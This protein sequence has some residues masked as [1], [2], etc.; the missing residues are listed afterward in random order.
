MPRRARVISPNGIYHVII[1][2][3]NK[4]NIF[5]DDKDRYH[6]IELLKNSV[7]DFSC[8]IYGFCLMGNH[9]H[10]LMKSEEVHVGRVMRT[11]GSKYV[12]WFN[13]KYFRTGCLFQDRFKSVP[14]RNT[15]QFTGTLRY[16]HQNPLL[17]GIVRNGCRYT[18]SSYLEYYRD[19]TCDK[20]IKGWD[21]IARDFTYSVLPREEF[22]RFHE[23]VQTDSENEVAFEIKS[24]L[25]RISDERASDLMAQISGCSNASDFQ[26]MDGELRECFL[27]DLLD[28]RLPI[29]QIVRIT[30]VSKGL[31]QKLR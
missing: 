24:R 29:V 4:Q 10:L 31:I 8:E 28:E 1:R 16:I 30:G 14:V 23:V 18:F 20:R 19:L 11:I 3:I 6:F 22:L 7:D 9:V 26:A 12:I 2:G 27:R 13:L 5:E 25:R 17:A 15:N 21:F